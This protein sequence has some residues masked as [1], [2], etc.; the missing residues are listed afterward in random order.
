M[1]IGLVHGDVHPG[2]PDRETGRGEAGAVTQLG[3]DRDR[4]Q[5]PDPVVSHERLAP[6]LPARV[7]AQL[8]VQRRQLPVERVDHRQRD[9]NR[10]A[11]R[12]RQR[13]SGEPLATV[14]GHQLTALRAP[15]VIQGRLDPLLP[16]AALLRQR[17]PQPDPRAEIEDVIRR[18]PRLRQPLDHQQLPQMP[19][20]RTITLRP[21]LRP[22]QASRL[23]RLGQMH[24]GTDPP[25][26]LDHEPPAGRRLE[27]HLQL[28]RAETRQ[29]PPNMRAI[30][31][32]HA[33]A[34]ARRAAARRASAAPRAR[35]RLVARRRLRVA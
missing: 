6:G 14:A 18:D 32:C 19:G 21:L 3:Q 35:V 23:R 22:A 30:R 27:R 7:R 33:G 34:G 26:L 8:P 29:P 10:L 11:R 17:V 1:L 5:R 31:G 9:R 13:L 28:P 25:Q 20:V 12:G 2:V 16:L 4:D 15:V 24:Q